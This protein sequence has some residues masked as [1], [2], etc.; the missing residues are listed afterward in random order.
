MRLI[1]LIR[2]KKK[3]AGLGL[4]ISRQLA[5]KLGGQL[6][7]KSK[8]GVGSIFTLTIQASKDK[9]ISETQ[10]NPLAD[11][12]VIKVLIVEDDTDLVELIKIYLHEHGYTTATAFDGEDALTLC[13]NEEFDLV[14]L[15]MQL[16]TLSGIEVAKQLNDSDFCIPIIGMTAST[17][18]E[19]KIEALNAGCDDFLIKPI[20]I[21]PLI[22]TINKLLI[23][24]V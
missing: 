20:Q 24:H 9:T 5:E 16:P 19:D 18:N 7:L 12:Q 6:E 8:L 22:S 13:K 14:L 15:D 2:K 10:I 3:G 23:E 11:K 21:S 17:S 1:V 4:A